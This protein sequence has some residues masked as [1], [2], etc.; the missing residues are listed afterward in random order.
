MTNAELLEYNRHRKVCQICI[1]VERDLE[2]VLDEWVDKLKVGPWTVLTISDE[3]VI[4]PRVN[5]KPLEGKFKYY[6]A[7]A[8]Y[9][10]VQ[11][12]IVKSVYGYF[13]AG[14]FLKR[15]GGGLQHFKEQFSS[16][17][18]MAEKARE[19]ELAGYPKTFSGG[20]KEDRFCN[21]DTERSLGFALEIGN[22][23]NISLTEDMYYIYPREQ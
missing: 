4:D 9:G 21:F 23:A 15:T 17:E 6:C 13:P 5:G 1:A 7:L 14:D 8:M 11:I 3:N 2:A 22:F 18:K 20:L 10:N 19:L 12:E 16:D